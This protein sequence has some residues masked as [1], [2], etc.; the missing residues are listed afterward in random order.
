VLSFV[1]QDHLFDGHAGHHLKSR[2]TAEQL[3]QRGPIAPWR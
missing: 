3:A 2:P 1:A